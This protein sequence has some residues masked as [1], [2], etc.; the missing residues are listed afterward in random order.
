MTSQAS[1]VSDD[2]RPLAF[3]PGEGAAYN[4]DDYEIFSRVPAGGNWESLDFLTRRAAMGDS[5]LSR[6]GG[7]RSRHFARLSWDKPSPTVLTNPTRRATGMCHPDETR[8][9]TPNECAAVQGFPVGYPFQGPLTARY[10]QIGNALPVELAY[11]AALAV[12]AAI[13]G[14]GA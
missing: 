14:R 7:G 2:T 1:D 3:D 10:T 9:L 6:R 4:P 11:A 13:Q 12:K 8:P 5:F